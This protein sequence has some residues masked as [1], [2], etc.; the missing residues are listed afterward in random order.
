MSLL[1]QTFLVGKD[2]KSG[3]DYNG[4][5]R[6]VSDSLPAAP[7]INLRINLTNTKAMRVDVAL[8]CLLE[9]GVQNR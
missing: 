8:Y 2:T 9:L 5:Q 7:L 6:T 1:Q 3:C 4:I